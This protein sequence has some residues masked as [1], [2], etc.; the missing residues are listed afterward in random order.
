MLI[1]MFSV[2]NI[3]NV[4]QTDDTFEMLLNC[5]ALI[6]VAE[7]DEDFCKSPWWDPGHRWIKAATVE[8][9][10]QYYVDI[11]ALRS[12]DLFALK[13]NMNP[14][15]LLEICDRDKSIFKNRVVARKDCRDMSLMTES[16]RIRFMSSELALLTGNKGAITEYCKEHQFFGKSEY[17]YILKPFYSFL[18]IFKPD[19]FITGG[20]FN[21][22]EQCRSWSRWHD[23]LYIGVLPDFQSVLT[24]LKKGSGKEDG[25]N[26]DDSTEADSITDDWNFDP[27]FRSSYGYFWTVTFFETLFLK[28]L[29]KKTLSSIAEGRLLDVLFWIYDAA[30]EWISFVFHIIFPIYCLWGIVLW[31]RC[32]ID[33]PPNQEDSSFNSGY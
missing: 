4:I 28:E 10:L 6:F 21:R 19:I 9:V 26:P 13:Y 20:V 22:Y 32:F 1:M 11:P 30:F 17:M 15:V 33:I 5:L 27:D 18:S 24:K 16:E 12:L 25:E 23:I 8:L 2:A 14:D 7:I 31:P 3:F 29:I